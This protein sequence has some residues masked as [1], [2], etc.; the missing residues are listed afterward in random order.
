MVRLF[1]IHFIGKASS[2]LEGIVI[3]EAITEMA[4]AASAVVDSSEGSANT[5]AIAIEVASLVV[6]V[7]LAAV[8]AVGCSPWHSAS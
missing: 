2:H 7:A 1:P 8:V 6:V 4:V 3:A 5:T